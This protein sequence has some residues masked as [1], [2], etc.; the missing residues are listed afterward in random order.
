MKVKCVGY[1]K[2]ERNFT[3]GKTYEVIN[4]RIKC[5]IGYTYHEGSNES[6]L[7]FLSKWYVFEPVNE[8]IVIYRKGNE[9]I[10]LDKRT[11]KKAVAKCCPEDTYNFDTGAKLA[12]ERLNENVSFTLLCINTYKS[13]DMCTRGKV[14]KFIN[15]RTK[16][17]DGNTSSYY[18]NFDDF[19]RENILFHKNFVE[20]KD[21]DNPEEILKKYDEIKVGDKVHIINSGLIHRGYV[22][23]VEHHIRAGRDLRYKFD[24]GNAPSMSNDF[25]VKYIAKHLSCDELL[26]YIQDLLTDRCYVI[27][28]KGLKKC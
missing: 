18:D 4:G 22:D 10:A 3:K 14:Y 5:D 13:F 19:K 1:K 27:E 25:K 2:G 7:K 17:D 23:W 15:G 12:F 26:A 16:W 20:L 28:V 11:G 8:T 9:T 21:G 6:L 24:Y